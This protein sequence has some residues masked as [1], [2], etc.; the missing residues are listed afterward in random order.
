MAISNYQHE[1]RKMLFETF[2]QFN[3]IYRAKIEPTG[4]RL[5]KV[6][7][8]NFPL[9]PG[10]PITYSTIDE[11]AIKM[12]QDEFE[13]FMRNWCEYVDMMYVAKEH[14]LIGEEYNKLLMLVNLLK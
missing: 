4:Q 1:Q 13:K 9:D 10:R 12:P 14:P 7:E 2:K 3:T 11:I 6:D 5:N 8:S